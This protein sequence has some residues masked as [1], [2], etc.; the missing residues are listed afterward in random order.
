VSNKYKRLI[1]IPVENLRPSQNVC[2][3]CHGPQYQFIERLETR[4][5]FLSDKKNTA[6]WVIDLFLKMGTSRIE[7]DTPPKIH[8]HYTVAKEIRYEATDPKRMRIPWIQVTEEIQ[9]IYGC[10]YDPAMKVSWKN[11]PD[12]T[13]HMY[14]LGCFR[15]HDGKHASNDGKVLSKD[16]TICHLLITHKVDWSKGQSL[17][18]LAAYP[19][20]V[21]IGDSY[22]K[23]NCSDCHGAGDYRLHDGHASDQSGQEAD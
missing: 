1:P 11:F 3:M 20:P 17:F 4:T 18:S 12:N 10:N 13:G 6:W 21:D 19:H 5:H 15:C 23:M 22:K 7:T 8:W 2:E 16:C 14:S 9:H